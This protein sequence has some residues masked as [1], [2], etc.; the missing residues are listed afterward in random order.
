MDRFWK[1]I[2]TGSQGT[3]TEESSS[4]R[5]Q[6]QEKPIRQRNRR[7][8]LADIEQIRGSRGNEGKFTK[9]EEST[10]VHTERVLRFLLTSL[11]SAVLQHQQLYSPF[12]GDTRYARVV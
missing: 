7:K 5:D 2:K 1:T 9:R 11:R 6:K 8:E 10:G 3:K 12:G 4:G